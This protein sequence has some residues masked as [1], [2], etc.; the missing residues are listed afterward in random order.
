M[1][2]Q[3]P[4]HQSESASWWFS[5]EDLNALDELL[6][7]EFQ[8]LA[9]CEDALVATQL[10]EKKRRYS[11]DELSNERIAAWTSELRADFARVARRSFAVVLKDK[12]SLVEGSL[13]ELRKKHDL[14][15]KVAIP[16]EFKAEIVRAGVSASIAVSEIGYLSLTVLPA[17]SEEAYQL[18]GKLSEWLDARR[19]GRAEGVFAQLGFVGGLAALVWAWIVFSINL[20]PAPSPYLEQARVLLNAGGV[21]IAT[22]DKAL[23]LMLGI[24]SSPD[25]GSAKIFNFPPLWQWSVFAALVIA[26]ILGGAAPRVIVGVGKGATYF[27]RWHRIRGWVVYVFPMFVVSSYVLPFLRRWLLP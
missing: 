24:L 5:K 11:E 3:S 22:R 9:R 7:V 21:S 25:A 12:Y 6:E 8:A 18:Y 17:T 26:S 13:S 20:R 14:H 15:L 2:T 1:A 4:G 19:P 23:E 27:K 16:T 10:E